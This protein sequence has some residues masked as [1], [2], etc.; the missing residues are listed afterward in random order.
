MLIGLVCCLCG[1]LPITA[2]FI[3]TYGQSP[4]FTLCS[5]LGFPDGSVSK[6]PACNAGD[7]KLSLSPLYF[8]KT[9]LTKALSDQASSL[10]PD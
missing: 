7:Q 10:A 2:V 1:S 3:A 6:E 5:V 8:N 9:L 4:L